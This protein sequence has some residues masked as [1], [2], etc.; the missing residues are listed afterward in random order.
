VAVE[1]NKGKRDGTSEN[2]VQKALKEAKRRIN[3]E[4]W[5]FYHQPTIFAVVYP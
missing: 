5:V 4:K 3:G 2:V 1:R